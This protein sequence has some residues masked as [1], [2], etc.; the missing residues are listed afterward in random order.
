[1]AVPGIPKIMLVE[2]DPQ[3]V[4]L[5]QRYARASGCLLIHSDA[6][7]QAISMAQKE[8]PDLI[9][10]DLVLNGADDWRSQSR[11]VLQAFKADPVTRKMP[12]IICSA[13]ETATRGWEETA[14]GCLLKPVMYEDFQAALTAAL[15]R[16]PAPA[17]A[18][19]C[20]SDAE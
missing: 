10:L 4:Y 8:L 20:G 12:V 3:F 6:T 9:L 7:D 15:A 17:V 14:E 11:Q 5:I 18:G 19:L 16:P 13:T 1:M 2:D